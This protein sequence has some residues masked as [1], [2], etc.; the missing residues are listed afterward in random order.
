M[1]FTLEGL[2]KEKALVNAIDW[3][4]TAVHAMKKKHQSGSCHQSGASLGVK[5]LIIFTKIIQGKAMS[6]VRGESKP[7]IS[8]GRMR[9][10]IIQK[11]IIPIPSRNETDSKGLINMSMTAFY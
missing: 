8:P 9:F 3:N 2:K 1:I 11:P 4:M 6:R 5:S 7:S 10:L